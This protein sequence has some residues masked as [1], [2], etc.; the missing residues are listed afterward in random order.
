MSTLSKGRCRVLI[1]Q[2]PNAHV[3]NLRILLS[4]AMAAAAVKKIYRWKYIAQ[5]YD[6]CATS[7]VKLKVDSMSRTDYDFVFLLFLYLV[8]FMDLLFF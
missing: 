4:N 6:P 1:Y 2:S 5:Y 7:F 3:Q 8:V